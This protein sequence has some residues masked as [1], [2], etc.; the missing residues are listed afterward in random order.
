MSVK[1]SY[2]SQTVLNQ[3]SVSVLKELKACYLSQAS[4]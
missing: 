1:W 2:R 3:K 4:F